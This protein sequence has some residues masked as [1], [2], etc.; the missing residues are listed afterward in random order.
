METTLAQ[1]ETQTDRKSVLHVGCGSPR[2][3]SLNAY[4]RDKERWQEIRLDIN[5]N[6][7][8][9]IVSDIRDM[10]P[11]DSESMDAV[12][13][14][15]NIEHLHSWEVPGALK[16]F[17][18]VLKPGGFLLITLPSIEVVAKHIVENGLETPMYHSPAGP[19]TPVDTIFGHQ[20]S[21]MRG[22]HFMAHKTA[23]TPKTLAQKLQVAGFDMIQ[24]TESGFDLWALAFRDHTQRTESIQLRSG[25]T[26]TA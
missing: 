4:F 19:I 11:V 13:S 14:S 1:T 21:L 15:H 26:P 17:Y 16:E 3:N 24:V 10:S 20:A 23:F 22:E 5:P 6:A 9:D 18:R 8:P 2:D 7:K 12:W 25:N